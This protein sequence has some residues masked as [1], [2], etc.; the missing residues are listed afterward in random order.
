MND[1]TLAAFLALLGL[2]AWWASSRRI[3]GQLGPKT[4]P[5]TAADVDALTRTLLAETSFH[6]EPAEMAAILW[7]AITRA[8]VNARSIAVTVTPPGS[9]TWNG[10]R[11]FRQRW[12]EAPQWRQWGRA[13]AFVQEVLSGAWP[14]QIGNRQHFLHPAG[15]PRCNSDRSCP[16]GRVCADTTAGPRCL[17]RWSTTA[18]VKIIGEARFS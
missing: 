12:N 3:R 10:S 1:T 14:N 18:N 13:R 11:Q 2:G 17:P 9:P 8:R 7:V 4:I 15:M 5:H 16:S 6:Q